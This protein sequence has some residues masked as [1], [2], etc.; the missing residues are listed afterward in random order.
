MA[1]VRLCAVLRELRDVGPATTHELA[2]VLDAH[3]DTAY[4]WVRKLYAEGVIVPTGENERAVRWQLAPP[5]T[6]TRAPYIVK[7]DLRRRGRIKET[8]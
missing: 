1:I 7:S 2:A 5:N 3:E 8:T 6:P 4:H